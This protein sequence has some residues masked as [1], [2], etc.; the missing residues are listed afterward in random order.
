MDLKG[1]KNPLS[2]L[3]EGAAMKAALTSG[4]EILFKVPASRFVK[5]GNTVGGTIHI[6]NKRVIF[7]A[8]NLNL[9]ASLRELT[10]TLP[11]D[12][13]TGYSIADNVGFANMVNLSGVN[14]DKAVK[15]QTVNS[16]NVYHVG[17]KAS[18]IVELLKKIC[19]NAVEL[20]K[21]GYLENLKGNILGRNVPL[22]LDIMNESSVTSKN[23]ASCPSCNANNED[24]VKFCGECGS[25][26]FIECSK[27]GAL[28]TKGQK[29]CNE[30]GI[31]LFPHCPQCGVDVKEGVK[32][33]NECGEKVM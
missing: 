23:A 6:T 14:K 13:I 17:G 26:L 11:V 21:E 28:I 29:F 18:N 2:S 25:K 20:G 1:L 3:T 15:I 22:A 30:C 12:E 16:A 9:T 27:C 33:C 4:E 19:P 10:D 5:A 7:E 31:S 24:G 8:G 32:F